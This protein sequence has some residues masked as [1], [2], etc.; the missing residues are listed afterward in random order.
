MS[1]TPTESERALI[2]PREIPAA[3]TVIDWVRGDIADAYNANFFSQLQRAVATR[4]CWWKGKN[5]DG[6][7]GDMPYGTRSG[8][9]PWSGA[10]DHEERTV[11]MICN[12]EARLALM[13]WL[14]SQ[15]TVRPRDAMNDD[16][17]TRATA[18]RH[19]LDFYLDATRRPFMHA[20]EL[21]ANAL[22][23]LGRS[24]WVEG[25]KDIW[26]VGRKNMAWQDVIQTAMKQAQQ[27]TPV[28]AEPSGDDS[29][30]QEPDMALMADLQM[31]RQDKTMD[32]EFTTLLLA[33]DPLLP[34]AEAAKVITQFRGS[35]RTPSADTATYY[36]PVKDRAVPTHE[37][38]LPGIDCLWPQMSEAGTDQESGVP[39]MIFF[40]WYTESRLRVE[41][42]Q[43][44]WDKDWLAAVL[45][46]GPGLAFDPG[47]WGG[48]GNMTWQLNG[49]DFGMQ[50]N[51][52]SLKNAGLYQVIKMWWQGV[53]DKGLG[54]PYRT[55]LNALI[56][57]RVAK[58]ECDPYGTGRMPFFL[59]TR[60]R[61]RRMANASTGV[62]DEMLTTQLGRK[63]LTDASISQSE[64]RANPPRIV[65]QEGGG[66]GLRPGASL[67]VSNKYLATG[68]PKFME[69]PDLSPGSLQM[70]EVLEKGMNEFYARGAEA[71]PDLKRTARI[72]QVGK[73]CGFFEDV[74]GLMALHIQ[75]GQTEPLNIGAIGDTVVNATVNPE[76]LQGELNIKVKCSEGSID[77]DDADTKMNQ[78]VNILRVADRNGVLDWDKITRELVMWVDPD[79]LS[80][81]ASGEQATARARNDQQQRITKMATNIALSYDHPADAP[82][83]RSAELAQWLQMPGTQTAVQNSPVLQKQVEREEQW[84]QFGVKQYQVNPQTGKT[85]VPPDMDMSELQGAGA[86]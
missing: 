57:N 50:Y 32:E 35:G 64:L 28:D 33:T 34:A 51:A 81:V 15:K 71:D 40:E 36:A 43:Y 1:Q 67:S 10:L 79:L 12:E 7:T 62:P 46:A 76:D 21:H 22:A 54:A 78:I 25:W 73:W 53:S 59:S 52:A 65:T 6:V 45:K 39:R 4:A 20:L 38:F 85:G 14:R 19:A 23:E 55:T 48:Q 37:V 86:Q 11:D 47:V 42:A 80:A 24:V 63:K 84:H 61:K 8:D 69:V 44:D 27:V 49:F 26:R 13:V 2:N 58:H 70:L 72:V 60:Q 5:V 30:E 66:N 17:T 83:A 16:Q 77:P 75:Q 74:L 82:Q 3:T 68:G 29:A 41:A 9:N 18:W 56:S 31:M